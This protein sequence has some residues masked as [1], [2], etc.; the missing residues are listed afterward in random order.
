MLNHITDPVCFAD[1]ME[2]IKK[3]F[4]PFESDELKEELSEKLKNNFREE[5]SKA[6]SPLHKDKIE[7]NPGIYSVFNESRRIFLNFIEKNSQYELLYINVA[8]KEK[9]ILPFVDRFHMLFSQRCWEE[10]YFRLDDD[11]DLAN[12]IRLVPENVDNKFDNNIKN[13]YSKHCGNY[14]HFLNVIAALSHLIVYFTGKKND[15]KPWFEKEI[16]SGYWDSIAY[17]AGPSERIFKLMLAAYYHDIGKTIVDH[18]HAMEGYNILSSYQSHVLKDFFTLANKCNEFPFNFSREDLLYIADLVFYHDLYGTLSTGENGYMRLIN[19]IEKVEK[20]TREFTIEPKSKLEIIREQGQKILFDIWLLN[21]AD[22]LVSVKDKYEIQDWVNTPPGSKKQLNNKIKEFFESHE[23]KDYKIR[24]ENG[25]LNQGYDLLHDLKITMNFYEIYTKYHY[26]KI[27]TDFKEAA[28]KCTRTHDIARIRRLVKNS[29]YPKVTK[30][31]NGIEKNKQLILLNKVISLTEKPQI[32]I[33]DLNIKDILALFLNSIV[34]QTRFSLDKTIE[35]AIKSTTEYNDFC[36]RLS[37]VGQLDYSLGFFKGLGETALEIILYQTIV[38]IKGDQGK[39]KHTGWINDK[40]KDYEN[41][42][43]IFKINAQYFIDNFVGT[44]VNTI[45]YLLFRD[46][47][48]EHIVNF[49][50]KD[51]QERLTF[52]KKNRILMFEGPSR[53]TKSTM[54]ILDTVFIY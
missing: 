9:Y 19:L 46:A 21:V 16:G 26:A 44:I 43:D 2:G 34:E 17:T 10:P 45:N 42:K 29:I 7:S 3:S 31:I 51:A 13:N 24:K 4:W 32:K 18:R 11:K 39:I 23:S 48:Y 28:I 5:M 8:K 54:S 1:C 14:N 22:I 53:S 35:V 6:G 47:F 15:H 52:E 50:F 30:F 33:N 41:Y 20:Y 12:L 36:K 27:S 49:E 37:W 40:L 25:F 38:L